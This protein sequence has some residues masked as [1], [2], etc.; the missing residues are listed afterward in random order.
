MKEDQ[1]HH[2]AIQS[3]INNHFIQVE[4]RIDP[5]CNSYFY[6]VR[7]IFKRHWRSKKDIPHDL[8]A[9]PRHSWNFVAKKIFKKK[10]KSLP[11]SGKVKEIENIISEQLLDLSGLEKKI[12]DYLIPYQKE[13]EKSLSDIFESVPVS[14]RKKFAKM[15]ESEIENLTTPIEGCRDAVMFLVAGIV[16]KVFSDKIV[17]GSMMS[18]G[19]A[20]A[21]SIYMSQLS[22]FG[23]LW[24]NIFGIPAWIGI[25]GAMGGIAAGI[26]VT[27]LVSP[28]FEFGINRLRAKK[29]LKEIVISAEEKL[30]DT[31]KDAF[32]V[33]GKIAIYLQVFPDIV[34]IA[35]K[36]AK[37]FF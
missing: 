34:H 6:N 22:W 10:F 25:A 4:K 9:I 11:K 5:I 29:I 27:P 20:I 35:K 14:N 28:L 3:I 7:E 31:G 15:L 12:E 1:K 2:N 37:V 36:T 33:A 17:F 21:S 30:T 18:T 13:F 16:G 26:I 23:A 24:A 8:A 32:N 19:K